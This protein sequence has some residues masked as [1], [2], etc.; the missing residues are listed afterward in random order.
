MEGGKSS[1]NDSSR[2]KSRRDA[3]MLTAYQAPAYRDPIV[4]NQ[5]KHMLTLSA[6]GHQV[7]SGRE[8]GD[9]KR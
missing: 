1:V 3:N 5:E 7:I 6:E 9:V 8:R 4:N 2:Q